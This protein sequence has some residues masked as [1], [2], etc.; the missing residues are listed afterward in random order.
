MQN[1]YRCET[2]NAQRAHALRAPKHEGRYRNG[3]M[4]Y[5]Y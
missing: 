2:H 4:E 3:P 5:L 1:R